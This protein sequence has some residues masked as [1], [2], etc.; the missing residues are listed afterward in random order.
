MIKAGCCFSAMIFKPITVFPEPGGAV[1][2]PNSLRE[3][4]SIAD[5]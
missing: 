3:A 5:S 2:T 1:I 4:A